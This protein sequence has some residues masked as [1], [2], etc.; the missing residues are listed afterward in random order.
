MI[1]Q[2]LEREYSELLHKFVNLELRQTAQSSIVRE[3]VS[4]GCAKITADD[5]FRFELVLRD[6]LRFK[7]W[8]YRPIVPSYFTARAS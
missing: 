5:V 2:S 8:H 1:A 3:F 7:T 4:Y 6:R